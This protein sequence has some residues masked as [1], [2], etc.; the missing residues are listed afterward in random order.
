MQEIRD[1]KFPKMKTDLQGNN[2]KELKENQITKEDKETKRIGELKR[3]NL[4]ENL[5]KYF[6]ICL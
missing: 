5:N 4:N 6:S 2:I 1:I 3:N